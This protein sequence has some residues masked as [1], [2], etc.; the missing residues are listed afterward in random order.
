MKHLHFISSYLIVLLIGSY[1]SL[2]FG[3]IVD[4]SAA[5]KKD[6]SRVKSKKTEKVDTLKIFRLN[7]T[8]FEKRE[9]KPFYK[10]IDTTLTGMQKTKFLREKDPFTQS[11]PNIGLA[12]RNLVFDKQYD[13]DFFSARQYFKDYFLTNDNAQYFQVNSPLAD[14]FFAMGP[15]REQTFN[16]LFT[17]NFI[18]N[19]NLSVNYKIIHANGTYLRQKSDNSFVILTGNYFTKNGRYVVL[20]SYFYNRMKIQENG[21]LLHDSTFLGTN[22]ASWQ[23][24]SIGLFNA[25]NR[26]R[27]SG[28]YV[29]QFYY[30]GIGGRTLKNDTSNAEIH[31]TGLGQISH[32]ILFK[33]QSYVYLDSLEGFNPIYSFNN[34][35]AHDSVHINT[36][37]NTLEWSNI[38]FLKESNYQ[39]LLL[40]L[41]IKH[42]YSKIYS[43]KTDTSLVSI[44]PQVDLQFKLK[45]GF[46][47][48][49]NGL[50]FLSGYNQGDYSYTGTIA[51]EKPSDTVS[52]ASFGATINVFRQSPS[53]F[54]EKYNSAFFNWNYKFNA[55]ISQKA[56]LFFNFKTLDL[57]LAYY[58]VKNYIYYSN[59]ALPMQYNHFFE[60]VQFKI[61]KDFKLKDWRLSNTIIYQK[62]FYTG[63]IRL[64]DLVSNNALYYTRQFFKSSLMAQ[65]GFEVTFLS[66]YYPLSWMPATKEFYLQGSFKSAN[67]PYV[68]LFLNAKIKRAKIFLKM[69]HVNAGLMGYDYFM[70]P[71]YP[72]LGRAFKF[73]VSW[74]FYD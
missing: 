60:L 31:Y 34:S 7:E 8:D 29:R 32:T 41:S 18:K 73:G 9:I 64:P 49:G 46:E 69:E 57:S 67:Y 47:V 24:D 55:T 6:T 23:V 54:D 37:E 61:C 63:V 16:F 3:Q 50:Y 14:A 19:L 35:A 20:G 11:F 15:K 1:C 28:F 71:H 52:K 17:R 44:I 36:I 53:L 10:R 43:I 39:T 22:H 70:T 21:G 65:L 58:Q 51:N 30:A 4:T 33:N 40:Q 59:L 72:M 5:K 66:S 12:Y 68:D 2:T 48:A 26:V 74:M 62:S 13:F 27:E 56:D 25:E 38:N 42:R 45:H